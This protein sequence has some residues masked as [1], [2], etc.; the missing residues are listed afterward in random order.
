MDKDMDEV[1]ADTMVSLSRV[2][3]LVAQVERLTKALEI[4]TVALRLID[5]TRFGWDGDAGV[6]FVA[7]DALDDIREAR[8]GK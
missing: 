4:A 2:A 3:D 7:G 5:G 1:E 8:T 6:C